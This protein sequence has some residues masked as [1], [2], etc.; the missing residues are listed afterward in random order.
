MLSKERVYASIN[1]DNI[2]D[3]VQNIK[4]NI[5][6][7]TSIIA[8]IKTDAYG[9]GAVRIGLELQPM[10]EISGFAVATIEEAVELKNAGIYK[11]ILIL[12]YSFPSAFETIVLNNIR[13]TVFELETAIELNEVAR[14]FN[15]QA[16]VHLKCDTGMSRIGFYPDD[17]GLNI[18]KEISKLSNITIE[19]IFTHFARADEQDKSHVLKQLQRFEEFLGRL[20]AEDINI[21]IK[22]C[23]NSASIIE[24][25]SANMN[26]V[27]AGIILYGLWPSDEVRRDVVELKPA[28]ELKS[29]VVYVKD[30]KPGTQISYGG[31]YVS[32]AAM[33]IATVTIGYGDGYPRALSNKGYVLVRGKKANIVGRVCMDQMM[34]DVTDIPGVSRGDTVTL[35]GKDGGEYISMEEFSEL[36]G[37]I[38]YESVCDIGKR[39]PRIYISDKHPF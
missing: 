23:S 11:P 28:M 33:R 27:R 22:H 26:M 38:N 3:N 20:D 39:V 15:R 36:S 25:K 2:R 13:S 14:K 12:G 4:K 21:P 10:P 32:K 34:I 7:D 30:V 9:H 8:V 17:E 24:L 31:T 16:I 29:T 37:R 6:E 35:I 5:S 18:V 1:L 19:G